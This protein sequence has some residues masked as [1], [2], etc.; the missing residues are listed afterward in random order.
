MNVVKDIDIL[1]W[2]PRCDR[3][4]A[5]LCFIPGG[6]SHLDPICDIKWDAA[7]PIKVDKSLIIQNNIA[8]CG[9]LLKTRCVGVIVSDKGLLIFSFIDNL[10]PILR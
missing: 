6:H 7:S 3:E 10:L 8:T 1:D 9:T 4:P 2:D 5:T